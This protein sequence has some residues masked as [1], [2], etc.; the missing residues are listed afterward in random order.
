MLCGCHPPRKHYSGYTDT[1]YVYLSSPT[2]GIVAHK[3]AERGALVQKHQKLYTL[4][5]S[6]DL[7][8]SKFAYDAYLQAQ[9]TYLDLT[10]PRRK[11]ERLAIQNQILQTNAAIRRV[12]TH[13]Q[14]LLKLREKQFVDADTIDNQT[15][16]LKELQFQKQ[17]LEENLNLANLGGRE[18]QIKAQ[19][20]YAKALYQKWLE[21]DWYLKLKTIKAPDS[22]YVFDTFYT[23]GELVPAQRPVVVMVIPKNN[24]VEF[25]VSAADLNAIQHGQ[26]IWYQFYNDK[27]QCEAIIDYISQTAEYMPPILY[28]SDYQQELV[29]RIRAKPLLNRKFPL[30]QPVDVWV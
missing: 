7:Q 8:Q 2:M 9:H 17:E 5:P 14:R 11:P 1:L 3:W 4:D 20:A 21:S 24:Y 19:Y 27:T 6:P 30:G 22:G 23:K 15:Q 25:F 13:L 18:E 16:T 29:F 26:H 10:R 12:D 28:T